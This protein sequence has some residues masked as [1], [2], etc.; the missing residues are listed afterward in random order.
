MSNEQ[1]AIYV[2][3]QDGA[4]YSKLLLPVGATQPV[5]QLIVPRFFKKKYHCLI[6]KHVLNQAPH[7]PIV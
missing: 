1:P 7:S 4:S 6:R 2:V 5:N 3:V